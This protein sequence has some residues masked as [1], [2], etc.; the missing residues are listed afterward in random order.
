MNLL[1]LDL[2]MNQP[3]GS[4]IQVGYCI[5]N[6][7]TGAIIYT[8]RHYVELPVGEKLCPKIT[9]LT[10]ITEQ[11]LA[12]Q[13]MDLQAAYILLQA[14]HKQ[15]NCLINPLTWGGGDSA[16]LRKQLGMEGGWAFGRRWID[17]KTVYVTRRLALGL[18]YQGGLAR[19]MTKLGLAFE[20]RKHD[21]LDDAIN[22]WRMYYK[23]VEE[24]RRK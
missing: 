22:T 20:G 21:A 1:T 23:L 19:S 9:E 10:G 16:E 6:L 18:P 14:A 12:T 17:T 4:I 15:H 8:G 5:G 3:S 24:I 7:E 13:G 11:H 2:E